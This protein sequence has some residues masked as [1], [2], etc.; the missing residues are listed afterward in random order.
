MIPTA[1]QFLLR[2]D[3][4]WGSSDERKLVTENVISTGMLSGERRKDFQGSI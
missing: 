4:G 3:G 1:I 2:A